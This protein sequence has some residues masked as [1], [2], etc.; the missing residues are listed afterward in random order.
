M[1]TAAAIAL[2]KQLKDIA[3]RLDADIEKAAG[4]RVAFTLL[5]YTD[6]RASYISTASREDSVREIKNLLGYW[7]Q[8]MP[9]VPAHQ[10]SS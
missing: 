7:E 8:G 4:E 9:D 3:K 10:L 6:G 2:S 1:S 5:V